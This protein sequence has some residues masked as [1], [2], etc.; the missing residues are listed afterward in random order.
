VKQKQRKKSELNRARTTH[1]SSTSVEKASQENEKRSKESNELITEKLRKFLDEDLKP[2]SLT[3]FSASQRVLNFNK[4]SS[5]VKILDIKMVAPSKITTVKK[6]NFDLRKKMVDIMESTKKEALRNNSFQISPFGSQQS[7]EGMPEEPQQSQNKT[8]EVTPTGSQHSAVNS[9]VN[10]KSGG[11]QHFQPGG[12]TV[13]SAKQEE[14]PLTPKDIATGSILKPPSQVITEKIDV[15]KQ[16][17]VSKFFNSKKKTVTF[18]S[19][20][21]KEAPQATPNSFQLFGGKENDKVEVYQSVKDVELFPKSFFFKNDGALRQDEKKVVG[22]KSKQTAAAAVAAP[23]VIRICKI[24][25]I[26]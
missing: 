3:S 21:R 4:D 11:S 14:K 20:T 16:E 1:N 13:S 7:Q 24:L 25:S 5:K 15:T 17:N 22:N 2:C 8:K 19:E 18:Q 23:E 6:P 26:E 12:V 9:K 10:L